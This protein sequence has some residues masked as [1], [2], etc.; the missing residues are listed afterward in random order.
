MRP[1][2]LAMLLS[3]TLACDESVSGPTVPLDREFVL[4]PGESAVVADI[5]LRF[6]QVANDSRCPADAVCVTG[7]DAQVQIA[8]T[9]ARGSRDYDLH[10]GDMKP[11]QHDDLTIHL[12]NVQP[13]PFSSRTIQP[14]DYRVTLR[15]TKT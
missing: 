5:S 8:V 15:V 6:L 13:Y 11:V 3:A 9:S 12:V 4:A 14:A 10:T 2:F 7:G 1:L